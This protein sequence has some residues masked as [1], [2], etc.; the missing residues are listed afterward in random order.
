MSVCILVV[1]GKLDITVSLF[2]GED[3]TFLIDFC[4]TGA[5]DNQDEYYSA[6]HKYL[7]AIGV[8]RG[9]PD[10]FKARNQIT[11]GWESIFVWPTINKNVDWI[12]YIYFNQQRFV[13]YTQDAIQ[14]IHEQLD[15]TSLKTWL[16]RMA[17]DM[18]LAENGGVC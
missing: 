7:C 10:E 1:A 2:K 12:N 4:S 6:D 11:A 18:L 3:R 15:K 14:R 17:L 9:V 13:N 8:P 16:N 5:C